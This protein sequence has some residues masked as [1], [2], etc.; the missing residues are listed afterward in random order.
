MIYLDKPDQFSPIFEVASCFFEHQGEV[1][2]LHRND[3]KGDDDTWGV[4]AGKIEIG[5]DPSQAMVRESREEIGFNIS[6]DDLIPFK[7]VYVKYP[8]YDFIFHMFHLTLKEKPNIVLNDESKDFKWLKPADALK[9]N[10][11][12][13]EDA[14]IKLMYFPDSKN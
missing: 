9:M 12:R 13:D 2:L 5:E 11:I 7:S 3:G 6:S 1:L 14:C 4:P 10:L 8:D